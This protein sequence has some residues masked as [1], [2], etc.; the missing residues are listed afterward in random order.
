MSSRRWAALAALFFCMTSGLVAAESLLY[1]KKAG[2]ETSSFSVTIEK[3][4]SGYSL[5]A[6][7]VKDGRFSLEV[8]MLTD[9][10]LATRQWR[11]IDPK[12]KL[13]LEAVRD[14]NRIDLSGTRDGVPVKKTFTID[15]KPWLQ[16][17]PFG[18]EDFALSKAASLDFWALSPDLLAC[19]LM[20]ASK[21]S[22]E[23]ISIQSGTRT[24]IRTHISLAA[25]LSAF[26]SADYWLSAADGHYIKFEGT[27]GPGTPD[28]VIELV[29]RRD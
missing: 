3:T 27:S 2:K 21:K 15:A 18:L 19:G 29:D 8:S 22:V 25:P 14:G 16:F 24:T 26:W 9:E 28:T 7:T 23:T 10:H 13:E 1:S 5:T 4:K 17:F 12:N 11:Y 6:G 20:S